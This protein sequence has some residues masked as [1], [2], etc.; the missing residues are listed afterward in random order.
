MSARHPVLLIDEDDGEAVRVLFD[1][2]ENQLRDGD[3]PAV[4]AALAR[5]LAAGESRATALRYIAC[6]LSVEFCEILEHG[7]QFDGERYAD[8]LEALPALPYDEDAI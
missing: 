5:L 8:N 4:A 7:G 3:P 6:A 2:V 1:T